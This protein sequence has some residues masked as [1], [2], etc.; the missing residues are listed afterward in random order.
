MK[1]IIPEDPRKR[2]ILVRRIV[3]GVTVVAVVGVTA[4]IL[5]KLDTIEVEVETLL[6]VTSDVVDAT[7]ALTDSLTIA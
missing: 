1:N 7:D 2:K 4:V 3:L 5:R 6:E